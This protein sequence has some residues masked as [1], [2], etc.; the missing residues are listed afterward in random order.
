MKKMRLQ[1]TRDW[2]FH[3]GDIQVLH[4]VKSGMTGGLTSSAEVEEGEWL[5]IAY[6]DEFEIE[7]PDESQWKEVSIPHD[8]CVEGE[9]RNDNGA[10]KHHKSHGYLDGGVGFYRKTF[11]ICEE[12]LGKRI[13]LEFEG[14][15][16]NCTIWVNGFEVM[17]HESGYTGF[18]C[19]LTDILRYG[20]EG[21][22]VI[23]VRVDARDYE[24]W[25]Y[26]GAGIY[27]KV[28]LEVK[29][30]LHIAR[31]GVY[32]STPK[33]DEKAAKVKAEVQ[34]INENVGEQKAV[35]KTEIRNPAGE[36][37]FWK[38]T[39]ATV[40]G[41]ETCVCKLDCEIMNPGL[42]CPENPVLYVLEA[43]VW[44]NGEETEC[45]L[46]EFGVKTSAFDAKK[47]FLLNGKPYV[48]KGTC[49]HQD[50]AGVGVALPDSLIEYKLK[51]LKE[52]GCNAYRSAHHPASLK[53]LELCDH[54]G[55]LV[56]NEN[57]KL[58][59]TEAG[60]RELKEL[61]CSSRNH[62]S[63]FMW[64]ME[65]EEILEGTVMGTR[66][67][68]TLVDITH[69]L[70]P[71][72][73][74]TAAMNHGWNDGGYSAA[75][76]V[77]GYNYGQRAGQ[78]VEDHRKFPDRKSLGTESA[79]CTVTRGIYEDDTVKGYC[80]EYQTRLPEW[81]CT[82][83]KAWTDVLNH[84]EL[85]GVFIWT[86]FDYRGEPT[87]C[88]WPNINSHFGVMDTCG[89]PKSTYYYLKAHWC[90]EPELFIMPH[91]NWKGQEGSKKRVWIETNCEEA[92]L[93]L[94]GESQGKKVRAPGGHLEWEVKYQPG[95]LEAVGYK[96]KEEIIRKKVCT[97]KEPKYIEL[98]PEKEWC[99]ADGE[100]TICVEVSLLDE[101]KNPVVTMD[102]KIRFRAEGSGEILGV[103]NGDPSCHEPDKA[104]ERSTFNGKCLVILQ[105]G[106][107][108]GK[109]VLCARAEGLE[110]AVLELEAKYP[111][112]AEE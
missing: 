107:K 31:N 62:A 19:E 75:A 60:I 32:I 64:S 55:L 93:Y 82:V 37:I 106:A 81:S 108:K 54:I 111:D 71:C 1:F 10:V 65:N 80:T 2:K 11:H 44:V 18:W 26:E 45:Q 17:R 12:W 29:E 41:L 5:K 46:T 76:D 77:V 92:E 8:W 100:D 67:L 101:E 39:E 73:P 74:V 20:K 94:N 47:G 14:I 59:S 22:N 96:D 52:M 104:W 99:R 33:A 13:G 98:Y 57:R 89:F 91:W 6:F 103:G 83:E 3:L 85:S 56:M 24:G 109:I 43:S 61:I 30:P 28:W 70:D 15:F 34:I 63:V 102:K 9:Y 79:S 38:E 97:S 53:L 69:K 7:Q 16:R 25:W 51:K 23:L 4:P 95:V 50:F 84:P 78:D 110:E 105:A 48:L 36:C 21:N 35:L 72:R 66:I 88:E 86:G 68:K 58:D 27:R 49:N 87:P 40:S 112:R 42:W 90:E